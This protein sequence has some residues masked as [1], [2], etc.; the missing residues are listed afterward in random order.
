M[1]ILLKIIS[2]VL[3]VSLILFPIFI[4]KRLH[5]RKAKNT[6]ILYFTICL[7]TT[8][9]LVLV[10][11]WWSDFSNQLLLSHYGYDFND[12]DTIERFQ[13]VAPENLDRVKNL[14]ISMMGIGWPLK[15]FMVYPFYFVYLVIVYSVLDYQRNKTKK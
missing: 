7:I 6:I 4:L 10:V 9:L 13:N 8:F 14:R 12:L 5:K 2:F 15:A 11:A 3:L 1:E